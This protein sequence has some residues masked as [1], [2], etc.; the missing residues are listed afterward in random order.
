MITEAAA[1]PPLAQSQTN[2]NPLYPWIVVFTASLF[3][4]WTFI[5]V[6]SFDTL[7]PYLL[8]TFSVNAHQLGNLSASYFYAEVLMVFPAGILLD[9]VST[10]LLILITM[11]IGILS[12]LGFAYTNN[13]Q[14]ANYVHALAGLS[15]AFCFLSALRLAVRWF[16]PRQ[17][18]L[19]SGLI[20]T[21]AMIGGVAAQTPMRILCEAVGW[22]QAVVYDA[23]LGVAIWILIAFLVRDYPSDYNHTQEGD[24]QQLHNLGFWHSIGLTLGNTQN[25]LA[26]LYTALLNL[27][28]ALLGALWGELF[29]K[30]AHH[31][32]YTTASYAIDA[33]F[34]G[35]IIGSPVFG[36]FSD[37]LGKRKL[38]MLGGV[39]LSLAVMV[40]I[41]QLSTPSITTLVSLFFVLGFIT[42]CQVISYP[43]IAESNS[44][45]LTGTAL[46]V[47]TIIIIGSYAVFQPL[48]GWLLDLHWD[49]HMLDNV[50]L[51]SRANFDLALMLIP[52]SFIVALI[53]SFFIK[54]T[55]CKQ[56][57]SV[58]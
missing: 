23:G 42:S 56:K 22:R 14:M 31:F 58:E 9:R 8:Q 47:A 3:F 18:A 24:N 52:A 43:L 54:E 38:P 20:V 44:P 16:P 37:H 4:F 19:V 46:A 29:L 25:W 55:F 26:G 40:V 41:M 50:R 36:W 10:R 48:F 6:N 57:E 12:T 30:Q 34:I 11:G 28:L 1:M 27:P 7:T 32:S 5:Q 13:L 35:T 49:G 15:A 17:L 51:Y 2:S 53:A 39:I 33:L 45:L 21:M